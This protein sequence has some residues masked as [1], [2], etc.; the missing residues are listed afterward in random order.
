[1]P[2]IIKYVVD[3]AALAI[4]YF[5]VLYPKWKRTG[6]RA[7]AVNTVMFIYLSGV[8]LVTLMPVITSLPFLF[9]HPY[10]PMNMAPFEDAI[11]GRGDFIRQ[12]V[13]NVIM[14][15]PFGFLY[16]LCRRT[17]GK[18][19]NMLRCLLMTVLLS[20]SIEL[21][22]PLINGAR[23]AD[24]TDIITNTAGAILGYIAYKPVLVLLKHRHTREKQ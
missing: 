12:I 11:N 18:S 5:I 7:A 20:L 16:P 2:K 8:M 23:N 17:S 10:T 21:L 6:R 22:Q 13:L 4:L 1:M 15:V 14:T 19:C 3:L 9:N 24:I